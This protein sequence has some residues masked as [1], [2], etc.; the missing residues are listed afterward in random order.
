[1]STLFEEKYSVQTK[2]DDILPPIDEAREA[3]DHPKTYS[4]DFAIRAAGFRA[5]RDDDFSAPNS[6]V[7]KDPDPVTA[8]RIASEL[9]EVVDEHRRG[10]LSPSSELERVVNSRPIVVAA[11]T[12]VIGVHL[13]QGV[14]IRRMPKGSLLSCRSFDREYDGV[15]RK[16]VP[17]I[18]KAALRLYVRERDEFGE[19]RVDLTIE[20]MR[21]FSEQHPP[22]G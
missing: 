21:E 8:F 11:G 7:I 15:F 1:V 3:V 5:L 6:A 20:E 14:E 22:Q 4:D 10:V 9:A 18:G 12:V 16:Q 19:E 2:L 17:K 13:D